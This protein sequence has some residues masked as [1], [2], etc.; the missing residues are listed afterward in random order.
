MVAGRMEYELKNMIGKNVEIP[1]TDTLE[2]RYERD[3]CLYAL[4]LAARAREAKQLDVKGASD[5][6][7]VLHSLSRSL[8]RDWLYRPTRKVFVQRVEARVAKHL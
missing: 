4:E 1:Y 6:A 8:L 7:T 5:A 3:T 2:R